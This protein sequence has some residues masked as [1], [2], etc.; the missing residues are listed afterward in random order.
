MHIFDKLTE[1]LEV[2]K[3]EIDES[4]EFTSSQKYDLKNLLEEVAS[5]I[6]DI[7]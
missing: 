6:N 3:Q 7:A 5:K 1:D 2:M 4:E